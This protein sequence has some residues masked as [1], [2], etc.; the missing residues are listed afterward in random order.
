ME[1][2]FKKSIKL[3]SSESSLRISRPGRNIFLTYMAKYQEELVFLSRPDTIS[4]KMVSWH[5]TTHLY[6]H[7][8]YITITSGVLHITSILN[9]YLFFKI[10]HC[11]LLHIWNPEVAPSHCIRNLTLWN[12]IISIH[13]WLGILCIAIVKKRFPNFSILSFLKIQIFMFMIPGVLSHTIVIVS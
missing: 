4:T 6:I 5:C 12:L 8:L 7:I 13:I 10:R 9:V 11:A 1:M 3:S 2:I